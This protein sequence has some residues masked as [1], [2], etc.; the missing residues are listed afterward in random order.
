M[1]IAIHKG[2]GGFELSDK[3]I[4]LVRERKPEILLEFD[5]FYIF[6]CYQDSLR[7]DPVL[8]GVCE[9]LGEE[10]NGE[11]ANIVIIEIPEGVEYA[12]ECNNTTGNEWVAEKHKCWD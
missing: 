4:L 6:N 8:L 12:I 3:A 2:I 11:N 9:E 1:K 7:S 10:A 5:G